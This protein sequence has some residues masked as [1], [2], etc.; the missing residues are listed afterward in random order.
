M[1]MG[2]SEQPNEVVDQAAC[3]RL[4]MDVLKRSTGGGCVLQTSGV[5][6]YA[7]V[8]PAPSGLDLKGTFRL[9]TDLICTI[10]DA[11]GVMGTPEGIS[12]VSVGGRKISGNAQ[13]RRW[14]SL[15]VHGTLLVDFD[16][17]LAEV[18]L[19]HPAREPAYRRGRSHR[20]FLVTLRS[21]GVNADR[22]AI[23][24]VALTAAR[25]VFRLG[26]AYESSCVDVGSC[27]VGTGASATS[28][29]PSVVIR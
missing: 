8:T 26:E 11:F 29:S 25:R 10:L 12:D 16:Y 19:R 27:G 17:D 1:V 3:A 23:E 18:V 4:G 28:A 14:K 7:L 5:L 9:G 2:S 24:R 20:D 15:L 6:N 13:A 21:L 22:R